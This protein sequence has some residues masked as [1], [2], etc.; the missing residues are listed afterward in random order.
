MANRDGS[1]WLDW[2]RFGPQAPWDSPMGAGKPA[3]PSKFSSSPYSPGP[4]KVVLESPGK[5]P[6]PPE[7]EL[8]LLRPPP[9]HHLYQDLLQ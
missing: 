9:L 8:D 2:A 4:L 1:N 5:P 6:T 7:K 3:I